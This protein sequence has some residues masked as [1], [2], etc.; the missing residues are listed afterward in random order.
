MKRLFIFVGLLMGLASP[1]F[2]YEN[3]SMG[4]FLDAHKDAEVAEVIDTKLA[5]IEH[6]LGWANIMIRHRGQTPLYCMAPKLRLNGGQLFDILRKYMKTRNKEADMEM[7]AT[8]APGMF[9]AMALQD[10]FPCPK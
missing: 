6:G 3:G 1:T 5:D 7:S 4:W 8:V 10:T 2:A 9:L